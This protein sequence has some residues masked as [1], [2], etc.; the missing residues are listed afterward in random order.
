MRDCKSKC[1]PTKWIQTRGS[2]FPE[3]LFSFISLLAV[4]G[5]MSDS[6]ISQI[7][8]TRDF[9]NMQSC[10]GGERKRKKNRSAD[11]LLASRSGFYCVASFTLS[12]ACA[13]ESA[14]VCSSCLM[15]SQWE[16]GLLAGP[17]IASHCFGCCF[18][19]CLR[20]KRCFTGINS[21]LVSCMHALSVCSCKFTYLCINGVFQACMCVCKHICSRCQFF[22]SEL[23]GKKSLSI[24]EAVTR[25]S[26]WYMVNSAEQTIFLHPLQSTVRTE[27]WEIRNKQT[28]SLIILQY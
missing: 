16:I 22:K 5:C 14:Y 20:R 17:V 24:S 7:T 27:K 3:K 19:S 8:P 12:P 26:A 6:A 13:C 4:A 18:S 15:R 25:L 2:C 9:R 11:C 21:Y 23:A 10:N 1:K 28:F